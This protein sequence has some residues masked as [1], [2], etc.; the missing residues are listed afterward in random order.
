MRSHRE[1]LQW[2]PLPL[3]RTL[4]LLSVIYLSFS[5]WGVFPADRANGKELWKG[6]ILIIHGIKKKKS[7]S[8][9]CC[10]GPFCSPLLK[11]YPL[12]DLQVSLFY[13]ESHPDQN[14]NIALLTNATKLTLFPGSISNFC[15]V[16]GRP[17][18]DMMTISEW[19]LISGCP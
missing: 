7:H 4:V 3:S 17:Q 15:L 16:P 5:K 9:L 19:F 18:M 8:S 10:S 6:S 13:L 11:L 1:T 2:L 12:Y 14:S